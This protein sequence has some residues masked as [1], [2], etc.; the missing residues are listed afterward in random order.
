MHNITKDVKFD[1]YGDLHLLG[2]DLNVVTDNMSIMYQNVMDRLMTNFNDYDLAENYGADY[3]G[4]IG[5]PVNE[6]LEQEVEVRAVKALT[7]DGFISPRD[8]MVI[9]LSG[10]NK[11]FIRISIKN[12]IEG[13]SFTDEFIVNAIYNTSSGTL[14]A[15]N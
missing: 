14:N 4:L 9:T 2:N 11:V 8:L 10:N 15:A 13:I 6:E 7:G 3:S 5:L 12:N 1:R